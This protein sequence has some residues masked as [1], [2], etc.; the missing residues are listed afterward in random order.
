[1]SSVSSGNSLERI[2]EYVAIEHEHPETNTGKPPA[3]W[4]ASGTLK[5]E[6][7]CARYSVDGPQVLHNLNF[8]IKSGERVG[9]GV[10][11]FVYYMI[12]ALY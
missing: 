3:Y 10:C 8:E 1:M 4:P 2:Y 5:V 6:D 7:L 12:R 9:V 11:S